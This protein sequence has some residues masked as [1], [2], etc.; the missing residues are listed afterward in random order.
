M[1]GESDLNEYWIGIL[2][3]KLFGSIVDLEVLIAESNTSVCLTKMS[4]RNGRWSKTNHT[5][6][7]QSRF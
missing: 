3:C 1:A 2:V 4:Y 7:E 5:N 6:S